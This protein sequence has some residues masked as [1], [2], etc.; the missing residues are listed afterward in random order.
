M[1][2][3]FLSVIGVAGYLFVI[4]WAFNHIDPWIAIGI[5]IVG[6]YIA[7]KQILKQLKNKNEK[8]I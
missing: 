2:K 5:F 8:S 3:A 7:L 1:T 6:L 4:N